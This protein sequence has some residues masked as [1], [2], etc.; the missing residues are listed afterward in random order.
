MSKKRIGIFGS[1]GSIGRQ[2]L[3]VIEAHPA[4]FEV[5]VLTAHSNDAL[6]IEQALKHRPNAVV[7]GD[8]SKYAAVKDV[9]FDQGSKC[10][11]DPPPWWK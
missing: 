5:E 2:A 7:I 11:P 8:E 3:E 10:S 1:T 6:L 4:L 9:L